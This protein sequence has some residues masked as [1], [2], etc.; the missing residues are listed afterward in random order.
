MPIWDKFPNYSSDEL[1]VLTAVAAETLIDSSADTSV[2]ADVLRLSTKSAAAQL[3]RILKE[4]VPS[5]QSAQIQTVLE[6]P[7]NS[8]KIALAVLGEI[9]QIPELAE[10]VAA[11]YQA[12][13]GEMAGPELLLLAG[14]VVIL[15]IRIKDLDFSA[16]GVKVSFDEAGKS[17]ETFVSGLIK[18]ITPGT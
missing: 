14:A 10:R 9:R 5:I 3:Q 13:T 4:Q 18:S 12:R 15:A 11:A 17:V 7:Q 8:Q 2:T 16:H 6:D 1:R